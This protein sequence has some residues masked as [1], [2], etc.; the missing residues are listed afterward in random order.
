MS[1]IVKIV[2]EDFTKHLS[3]DFTVSNVCNYHCHYCHPGSNEGTSQSPKDFD[4]LIKNF[5]HLLN[6]YKNNFNKTEIKIEI[7]GGEP[8]VWP[9][10]QDFARYIKENHQVQNIALTTNASRT[11]RWWEE[12]GKYFDEVHI[13]LHDE[14]DVNHII[15]VADFLYKETENHVAVNVI[16]DPTNWDK[17]KVNLDKVVNHNIPWLV[18]TWV[19]TKDGHIRTDYTNEQLEMFRDK[20]HKMPPQEYIDK[21]LAR[22]IIPPKSTAKFIYDDGSI[23]PYNSFMLRSNNNHNFYGWQCNLGVDRIPIIFGDLVGSCGA[24]NIFNLEEPLSLY[25]EGFISKFTTDIISPIIC[26]Q[27]SCGSCTKDLKIPKHSLGGYSKIIPI[28][29]EK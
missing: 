1:N 7:T 12:N 22:K 25:D 10:L 11:M 29:N 16:M 24:R 8:T 14:C 4:L 17:C 26:K 6:T 3:I 5:D 23:E 9:R 13:S 2:N 20:V 27:Y 21:M 18:K 28:I 19:L 15:Q